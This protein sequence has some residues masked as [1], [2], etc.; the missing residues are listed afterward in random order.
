MG[1][2]NRYLGDY[3][4]DNDIYS[5]H[6]QTLFF[7][8]ILRIEFDQDNEPNTFAPA[9]N[10]RKFL[11]IRVRNSGKSTAHDC[12]A[13]VKVI[14]P[15]NVES[16]KFPSD[17]AK[18]LV[19]GLKPD[20]SD[21]KES[22]NIKK[23][24]TEMLHVVFADSIFPSVP[25]QE[26]T[27]YASFSTMDKFSKR[28]LTVQDSFSDGEFEIEISINAEETNTTTISD[29]K[30]EDLNDTSFIDKMISETTDPELIAQLEKQKRNCVFY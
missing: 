22:I 17:D 2:T 3:Y 7:R 14:I 8:P 23:N 6:S 5:Y 30:Y 13:T 24:S 26:G 15:P 29:K 25:F 20:L 12:E 11:K 19:W 28:S 10:P 21:L 27:R 4:C 1:R 9:S 16:Y 18:K